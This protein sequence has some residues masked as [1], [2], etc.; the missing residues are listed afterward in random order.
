MDSQVSFGNSVAFLVDND[1]LKEKIFKEVENILNI[2][3]KRDHF[4]G[5]QPVAVMKK[6]FE[7]LKTQRYVVCE[8][9][10]GERHVLLLL[11]NCILVIANDLTYIAN[12]I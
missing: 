3:C 5:P 4:P 11:N 7:T 8:K 6:D 12:D 2:I 9:T 10:D 1:V